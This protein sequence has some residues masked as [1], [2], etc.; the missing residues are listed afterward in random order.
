MEVT[1]GDLVPIPK[2]VGQFYPRQFA[3][4]G[5]QD[6]FISLTTD[7]GHGYILLTDTM[8]DLLFDELTTYRAKRAEKQE[9]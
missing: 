4:I 3:F 1:D 9:K 6:P 2:L 8:I 7:Q 5:G